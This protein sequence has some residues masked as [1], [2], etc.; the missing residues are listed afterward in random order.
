MWFICKICIFRWWN[1]DSDLE[2]ISFDH[3]R[4]FP[5]ENPRWRT[6]SGRRSFCSSRQ[7]PL[8]PPDWRVSAALPRVRL[9]LFL[10]MCAGHVWASSPRDIGRDTAWVPSPDFQAQLKKR[11]LGPKR[12]CPN[13]QNG[14]ISVVI[15]RSNAFTRSKQPWN[16]NEKR[17]IF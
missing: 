10:P 14:V 12:I 11:D 17:S 13:Q 9:M 16:E 8:L 1:G 5:Q 7:P 4:S 15:Y 2:S 6:I 3:H